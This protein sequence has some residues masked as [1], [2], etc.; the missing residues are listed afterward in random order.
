MEQMERGIERID[1]AWTN[2]QH[3]MKAAMEGP[4]APETAQALEEL[5]RQFEEAMDDDF[6]AANAIGVLF[7]GARLANELVGRD[8][9]SRDSFR[10]SPI[11]CSD[12]AADLSFWWKS[13]RKSRDR[14]TGGGIDPGATG[15]P[16]T[17]RFA[18]G[19]RFAT[20]D[21]FW[22]WGSSWKIHRGGPLA[23]KS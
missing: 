10:R 15:G 6:N 21:R 22:R 17:P 13:R 2:L 23:A 16:E 18:A 4:L 3:R 20:S 14:R 19:A 8:V 11:G 1:T 5:T 12:T 9:V 7:E